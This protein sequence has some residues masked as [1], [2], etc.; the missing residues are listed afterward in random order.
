MKRSLQTMLSIILL[1]STLVSLAPVFGAEAEA[2]GVK[3]TTPEPVS[4]MVILERIEFLADKLKGK[5]FTSDQEKGTTDSSNGHINNVR[6]AA[7]LKEAVGLVPNS[8][9]A[10][11]DIMP[12]KFYKKSYNYASS[13]SCSAFASFAAWFIFAQRDTDKVF[14]SKVA[15]GKFNEDFL[16]QARPGDIIAIYK[17]SSGGGNKHFVIF[18]SFE[19]DGIKVL[20]GNRSGDC[21]V[22]FSKIKYGWRK[23]ASISRK[24]NY[25]EDE[26]LYGPKYTISYIANA[27]DDG[28]LSGKMMDSFLAVD[29]EQTLRKN[30]YKV[31][32]YTFTGWNTKAN[33]SGKAYQDGQK[34]KN[35]AKEGATRKLYAQWKEDYLSKCPKPTT[36][37][38]S[39]KASNSKDYIM[40][41]PCSS[42]TSKGSV[43][44]RKLTRG[45]VLTTTA[46]YKNTEGNYWYQ[47]TAES[48]GATGYV[49]GGCVKVSGVPDKAITGNAKLK[50][51]TPKIK[52]S[53]AI[54]GTIKSKTLKIKTIEGVLTGSNGDQQSQTVSVKKNNYTI[55]SNSPIDK[56]LKFASLKHGPGT[57]QLAV[58]LTGKYTDGNELIS[59][60]WTK[61]LS[62]VKFT[63]IGSYN[64]KFNANG[65]MNAPETVKK[66][67]LK[68]LMLPSGK[69]SYSGYTFQGWATSKTA[70]KAKFKAGGTLDIDNEN[71]GALTLYAVWKKDSGST[72]SSKI[73]I[74]ATNFPDAKFREYVKG[75][76]TN[77]D[78]YLSLSERNNV[79]TIN[80][81][82]KEISSLKGLE[83]FPEV[84]HLDCNNNA[85]KT[86]DVTQNTKLYELDCSNNQ[87]TSLN[88]SKNTELV[89]F[90]C[91]G[92]QIKSLDV[93]KNAILGYLICSENQISSLD[94]SKNKELEWIICDGNRL[95]SLNISNNLKMTHLNCIGN[96]LT[97][98]DLSKNTNL[99][100]VSCN[101]N[102]LTTLKIGTNKNLHMLNCYHN[103][104]TSLNLSKCPVMVELLQDDT[105]N[106]YYY[107]EEAK[108]FNF[109][110]SNNGWTEQL[111]CDSSVNL[112]PAP[113]NPK[114]PVAEESEA[115]AD[116]S[117][118]VVE[119]ED[120]QAQADAQNEIAVEPAVETG[121]ITEQPVE[122]E[123]IDV[124][125]PVVEPEPIP[126]PVDI[127][128]A[129]AT[130]KSETDASAATEENTDAIVEP[131]WSDGGL[132]EQ[133]AEPEDT[134]I[135]AVT[136]EPEADAGF[137]PVFVP[138][139][140]E[141]F[142][143]PVVSE[144][145]PVVD[146]VPESEP[147]LEAE[148]YGFDETVPEDAVMDSPDPMI[149]EEFIS[150]DV[151]EFT[152]TI[153]E[154]SSLEPEEISE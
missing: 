45:E 152:E 82:F 97:S 131:E 12:K 23:Y 126:E 130:E 113:V 143:E 89:W 50:T 51:T 106:K 79:V 94:V 14:Y 59:G 74:N 132:A 2:A 144:E 48:D 142:A 52:K 6:K 72:T 58:T 91:S 64:V 154:E 3:K 153:T 30:T 10:V 150:E 90:H 76:D 18:H 148:A 26:N 101:D 67:D 46:I 44:V 22:K 34:V 100:S 110:R 135:I 117:G 81:R 70:T 62:K 120:A 147:L 121:L 145:I 118:I 24:T 41:W 20:D 19:E 107:N 102:R 35:L 16:S 139:S 108:T 112:T 21:A 56:N 68:D 133:A 111:W 109:C 17:K 99:G 27:P 141:E 15:D 84:T 77:S 38:L 137:E 40:S 1:L 43:A 119:T 66:T 73:K 85:L 103:N 13:K 69:P 86:L 4:E 71:G 122:P 95:T 98:L 138:E 47:V 36:T 136:E 128:I 93:S 123:V 61:M 63:V 125:E 31:N 127:E 105:D 8:K 60:T 114:E 151:P 124:A 25:I 80:C 7:W 32:G 78:N 28:E 129:E 146:E 9:L 140:V 65:G 87:L 75:F 88:V 104:I 115:N 11:N 96:Q 134:E 54:S 83:Y 37:Y 39:L 42:K 92:N 149:S 53:D 116:A 5:Y 49:F 29:Q 33:G 57:L 55:N